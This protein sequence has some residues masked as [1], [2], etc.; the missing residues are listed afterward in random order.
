MKPSSGWPPDASGLQPAASSLLRWTALG[1]LFVAAILGCGTQGE[2]YK[3][4]AVKLADQVERKAT[5]PAMP[6]GAVVRDTPPGECVT[7]DL[8]CGDTVEGTT[9]GGH[10]DWDLEFYRSKFCTPSGDYSAPERVYT[11]NVPKYTAA[12][13]E[14]QSDCVD[15]DLFALS[16]TYTGGAC[17]DIEHSVPNCSAN[18]DVGGGELELQSFQDPGVYLLSVDGKAGAV[19]TF[20]L[21]V[22]CE[23]IIR[24]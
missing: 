6:C 24:R 12:T 5:T 2:L 15:L 20:R 10:H 13:V 23:D 18:I 4:Q 21:T 19:G 3:Q 8:K 16:Y 1:A 7:S 14:L 17:P 9:L 11:L 22:R